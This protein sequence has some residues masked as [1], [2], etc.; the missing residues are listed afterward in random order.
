MMTDMLSPQPWST[1]R[2]CC[3]AQALKPTAPPTKP[4]DM[5]PVMKMRNMISSLPMLSLGRMLMPGM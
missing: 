4:M 2:I 3:T 5:Q 1:G